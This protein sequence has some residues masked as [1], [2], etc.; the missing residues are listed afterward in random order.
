MMSDL[1]LDAV[2]ADE[3]PA[4]AK[5]KIG[6]HEYSPGRHDWKPIDGTTRFTCSSCGLDPGV[7]FASRAMERCPNKPDACMYC[8]EP[9]DKHPGY[10]PQDLLRELDGLRR[11][12]LTDFRSAQGQPRQSAPDEMQHAIDTYFDSVDERLSATREEWATSWM[13]RHGSPSFSETLAD[14]TPNTANAQ[15]AMHRMEAN[16]EAYSRAYRL[17]DYE[18]LPAGLEFPWGVPTPGDPE[19]IDLIVDQLPDHPAAIEF[20]RAMGESTGESADAADQERAAYSFGVRAGQIQQSY[21][22]G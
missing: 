9:A 7:D 19:L 22:P 5:P 16:E 4:P 18:R 10:L 12:F 11:E 13:T 21:P 8:D 15:P 14:I 20:G 1:W 2:L 6:P 17:I 3:N